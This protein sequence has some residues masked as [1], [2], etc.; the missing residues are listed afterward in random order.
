LKFK[1]IYPNRRY[2]LPYLPFFNAKIRPAS[3]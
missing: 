3:I 1:L 2:F